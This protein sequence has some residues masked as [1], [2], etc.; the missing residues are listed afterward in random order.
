MVG[1]WN[2]A[3]IRMYRFCD[4]VQVD[5]E[6]NRENRKITKEWRAKQAAKKKIMTARIKEMTKWNFKKRQKQV[7]I[8]TCIDS[9][10]MC[11]ELVQMLLSLL[12]HSAR[13]L[14]A[15]VCWWS[16]TEVWSY[17]HSLVMTSDGAASL[18]LRMMKYWM[19]LP[20]KVAT[21]WWFSEIMS[22]GHLQ[23]EVL[24]IFWFEWGM[25]IKY[26]FHVIKVE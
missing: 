24:L 15:C 18:Q 13:N 4:V 20:V 17:W 2:L 5:T 14:F 19:Q 25:V 7:K 3:S 6:T 1:M 22:H 12:L 8:Q 9:L 21:F 10:D 16:W 23:L 26:Q 11:K